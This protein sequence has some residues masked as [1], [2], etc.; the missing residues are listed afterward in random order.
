MSSPWR[1]LAALVRRGALVRR[2]VLVALVALSGCQLPVDHVEQPPQ[3]ERL[4]AALTCAEAEIERQVVL[5]G[6]Y[7]RDD[8]FSYTVDAAQLLELAALRGDRAL[9][10]RLRQ[11]LLDT[12]V[13]QSAD[14]AFTDG[15]VAWRY[16]VGLPLDATGT[17][18]ALRV[19]SGLW[20]G[21]GLTAVDDTQLVLRI[22]RG[23]GRHAYVD[24]GTWMI[25]NYY[26]LIVR[27]FSINSYMVDYDPDL[28]AEVGAASG[29]VDV[30][31]VAERSYRLVDAAQAPSGLIYQVVQPELVTLLP[32]DKPIFSPN[33]IVGVANSCTVAERALRGRPEV[34]RR[35]LDFARAQG[36]R[37]AERHRGRDGRPIEG[38]RAANL[39]TRGCLAR[40]ALGLGDARRGDVARHLRAMLGELEPRCAA[41]E[42]IDLYTLSEV[43]RTLALATR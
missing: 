38:V 15:F 11:R 5:E 29:D 25:R 43:G 24:Q 16:G 31:D 27:A 9:F 23:Y 42:A 33:D 14:N 6:V 7:R 34:A 1:A 20:L 2:V 10:F 36:A 41:G 40:L 39:I 32:G 26:N 37:L 19:A 22:L 35:L 13:I 8:G 3:A 28:L 30:Q 4:V 17:T 21:R 18:E 12:V